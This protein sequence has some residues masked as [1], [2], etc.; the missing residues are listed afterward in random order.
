MKATRR[1]WW[2]AG[3]A[4]LLA[5]CAAG[6]ND[7]IDTANVQGD[8]AG[9]WR[10]LWHGLIAPLTFVVSL[11]THQVRVYEVH[12]VGTWYDFGFLLGVSVAFGGGGG[13]AVW[14]RRNKKI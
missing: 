5:G 9:F 4:L 1:L 13:H 7:L 10:G 3:L 11:F 2:V 6:A 12:N 14:R 8:I